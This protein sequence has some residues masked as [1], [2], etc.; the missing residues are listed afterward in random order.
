MSV[1][2]IASKKKDGLK[3][4]L[5]RGEDMVLLAFDID[6]SLRKP[7]F[8]GFGIQYRVGDSAE[9]RDVYNFLTFKKLREQAKAEAAA[10]TTEEKKA[11]AKKKASDNLKSRRSPLQL[12]RWA[13][14]P[15][16]PLDGPVTYRVSAMFWNGDQPPIAKATVE[17]TINANRTTRDDFLNIGFTRGFA[18]SQ[19][20]ERK[21][22]NQRK[23]I[24][25]SGKPEIDFD[26]TPFEG[27]KL[28]YPWLGFEARKILLGFMDECAAD[29]D[30]SVDV[31]AYDLSN[32]E[33]V[34]RL[35]A[36]GSRLRIVIDNSDPHGEAESDE[37]AAEKRLKQSAG[38]ANVVRHHF[39]GLQHNKV[40]IAKRKTA[41][42]FSPFAVLTGSTNFSLSGF[43]IQNNNVLLFRDAGVAK[44]Y[45]E[46]FAAGFPTHTGFSGK[47]VA[48][49]WFPVGL[50][51]A[52]SYR[53]CF[54][55]HK[56]VALSLE[57]V[58]DAID[59]AKKSVFYAIAFRGSMGGPVDDA[60]D[61]LD[62]KKFLVMGVASMPGKPKAKTVMVQLPG[63]GPVPIGPAALEKDLPEPFKAEWKG[64]GGIHMHHKFVVC[65][66]NGEHPV[67]FTGSSNL[68]GAE[69]SNG[70]NLIEIRDPK[71]VIAY[72]VQAVT[73]FDHYGF[74][75][76]MK[77]AE[78][79]PAV[80]DLSE[81]PA[82]GKPTWWEKSFQKNEYKCRDR[83]LFSS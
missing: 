30:V 38:P 79:K 62:P 5:Y 2:F 26:T 27:D 82:A 24:P 49:Q 32:P 42:G 64:G 67:V 14:V 57:P 77:N 6:E 17:A 21:F 20:Y 8:V 1:D 54:S 71:V 35:E 44:L 4:K 19:A 3:L 83:E 56:K 7:D 50:P 78:K 58:A 9:V 34:R 10:A 65:D 72:A 51:N 43:Y 66:F 41:G 81:P 18:S 60:L 36:F 52:G 61:K 15:S 28:P 70:D 12:F 74:R 29:P 11:A 22:P 53:F 39:S 75:N 48:A 45:A 47:P 31:F 13:H 23:I 80:R 68:A 25:P 46:V 63:R 73:I 55:P 76:R 40:I 33:I 69:K 16:V 59:D 37:T